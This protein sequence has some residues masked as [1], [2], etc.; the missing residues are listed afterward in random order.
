MPT[1]EKPKKAP[2]SKKKKTTKKTPIKRAK[3]LRF[4]VKDITY[5]HTEKERLFCDYYLQNRG[6]RVNAVIEAG[7][8]VRYKKKGVPTGGINRPLCSAI[9]YENLKK[10]HI[11]EYINSKLTE[12]GF[13]DDNVDLQL[14]HIVNQDADLRAKNTAISEYNKIKGRHSPQKHEHVVKTVNVIKYGKK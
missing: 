4:K 9:A 14:L 8:D 12:Y 2:A 1:K 13:D 7:Y 10:P 6:D 11:Y 3:H 5:S